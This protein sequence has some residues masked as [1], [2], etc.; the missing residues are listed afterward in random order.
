VSQNHSSLRTDTP[1]NA[2]HAIPANDVVARIES[3]TAG[4]T[5]AEAE[6]RLTRDGPNR[7]PAPRRPGQLQR[8]LGQFNNALVYILLAA[9]LATA[10]LGHWT[11]T[12]VILVVTLVNAVI[13]FLQEDRAERAIESIQ[14]ILPAQAK[15]R[16]DGTRLILP[17]DQIVVGDIVLLEPGDHVPAD[18]RL[19]EAK[20]LQIQE[21]VLT[22]ESLPVEKT[23]QPVRESTPLGDRAGMAYSGTSVATGYGAG[24]VVATGLGTE[25]GHISRL[26]RDIRPLATPLLHKMQAFGRR[27]TMA[28]LVLAAATFAVGVL[29]RGYPAEEMVLASVGLAVAAIPEG[30]PAILTIILAI[31][32]QRMARRNALIRHLPVVETL[33]TVTV[34][35][36]DKTGTLTRNELTV[37]SI[38]LAD[39]VIDVTGSGYAPQGAFLRR[40]EGVVADGHPGVRELLR[41]ALLCNDASLRGRNGDWQVIGDPTEGALVS[42]AAKAGFDAVSERGKFPRLDVIPFESERRLMAT[43]HQDDI[44]RRFI[45]VKGAPEQILALCDREAASKGNR[46]LNPG[47]WERQVVELAANGARV[48]AVAMKAVDNAQERLD[49]S[50]LSPGFT[51]LGLLG[52][53]DP[54]REEA[55]AAIRRCHAAGILVKM[56]T[57]DHAATAR[58]IARRLGLDHADT[59]LTGADVDQIS[60]SALSERVTQ[61]DVFARMTAEQKLR[62]V[63]ALQQRRQITVMTGDGVNDAPAL[64]RADVGVA[65]GL[66]GSDSARQAAQVVLADDNFASIAAAVEEGRTVDDNLRKAIL[67]ILPTSIAEAAMII[68]AVLIGHTLPITAIQ[69]LWVNMVTE[70]TLSLALAFEPAEADNMSRPPR[71]TDES[72]LSGYLVWRVLLVTV[73]F[74]SGSFGLFLWELDR[75]VSIAEARTVAVNTLVMFEVFYLFNC[76]FLSA[77]SLSRSG[78]LGNWIALAAIASV[79]CLQLFFTYLPLMQSVFDSHPLDV[80]AWARVILVSA[81]VFIFVELEKW[82]LRSRANPRAAV[83]RPP[84]QSSPGT[85]P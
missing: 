18:M 21:A 1:V 62:L 54:P 73:I 15:V 11:D 38:V 66:M 68:I 25:I 8:F 84:I 34:I 82:M 33:G 81:S 6:A 22:G 59:V 63:A 83:V 32:V 48:L 31:G 78:L 3:S 75:G 65:M 52:L 80:A 16:R 85:E 39:E 10:A 41:Q 67:Y 29:L 42:V 49:I 24:V 20:N 55:I 7:I 2:W 57:G 69:I 76:R 53:T 46:D 72:L 12:G 71:L 79:I 28:I 19:F 60:D 74:L 47:G 5:T 36:S 58:A 35:C 30:L 13:G 44:G 51:L 61:V 56:I 43:L 26:L 37:T 27:L 14:R 50:D 17:V 4:L 70:V 9:S 64:K 23:P 40:G 77:T 45:S